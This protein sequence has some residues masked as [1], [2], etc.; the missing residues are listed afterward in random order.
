MVM[1][2]KK[3]SAFGSQMHKKCTHRINEE[4]SGYLKQL[5]HLSKL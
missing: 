3:G 5:D 4:N 1:K 2:G